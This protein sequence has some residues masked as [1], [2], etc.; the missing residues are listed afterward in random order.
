ML[1][2][3]MCLAGVY[4]GMAIEKTNVLPDQRAQGFACK[5]SDEH[6][7]LM[8]SDEE[9]TNYKP[10]YCGSAK[11]SSDGDV[12]FTTCGTVGAGAGC[13]IVTN[14]AKPYPDCCPKVVC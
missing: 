11:C 10:N 14:S 4:C 2:F 1:I 6:L 9:R 3:A 12:T 5:S 13:Q 7:G 8:R